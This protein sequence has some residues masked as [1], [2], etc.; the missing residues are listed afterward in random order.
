VV[1]ISI[2]GEH[3]PSCVQ[4]RQVYLR[5]LVT[6]LDDF[7]EALNEPKVGELAAAGSG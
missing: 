3:I 5:M 7:L 4:R 2:S 6:E 1:L